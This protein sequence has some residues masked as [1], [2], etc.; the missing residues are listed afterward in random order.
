MSGL[1]VAALARYPVKSM[2]GEPLPG[3]AVDRRGVQGDRAW[4]VRT[5]RGKLGSGKDGSRFERVDGLLRL[6]AAGAPTP[7]L[8]LPDGSTVSADDP[9]ADATLSA[10]LGR[11]VTLRREPAVGQG[12]FDDGPV[13]LVTT[14]S[15]H[16]LSRALGRPCPP[17]R[18]RAN[19]VV[20][21]GDEAYVED[22]WVGR[23][24][25]VGGAE[26]VVEAPLTRCV[27]VDAATRDLPRDGQVLRTLGGLHD[28][29]FGVVATVAR[30]G[31]L[32][33]GDGVAVA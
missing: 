31:W 14:G 22:G 16:A 10:V 18:F 4:A 12:H 32:A 28:T 30:P 20:D 24:L 11:A 6:S 25:R 3:V 13:S 19:V 23:R 7:V 15:L 9:G 5:A 8:T 21:T 33:V 1:T 17:D 29:C 2:L 27:M 26:L